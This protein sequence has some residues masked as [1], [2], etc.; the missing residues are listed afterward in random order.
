MA[1]PSNSTTGASTDASIFRI[2]HELRKCSPEKY[3]T[4]LEHLG[5]Q[6]IENAQIRETIELDNAGRVQ[7]A[8]VKV[9]EAKKALEQAEH[10]AANKLK[11][12]DMKVDELV[13][14]RDVVHDV[15]WERG[16]LTGREDTR[17]FDAY[18]RRRR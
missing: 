11:L 13:K 15:M 1:Q 9:E 7:K 4:Y 3:A 2:K 18:G 8:M 16:E 5:A 17:H 6:I 14:M 10:D 12:H